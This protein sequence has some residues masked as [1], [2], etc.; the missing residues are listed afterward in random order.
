MMCIFYCSSGKA[1]SKMGANGTSEITAACNK[2]CACSTFI[3]Q[4]VCGSNNVAYF[5]PCHAGCMVKLTEKV[6][7]NTIVSRFTNIS[8]CVPQ[9]ILVCSLTYPHVLLTYPHVFPNI[10]SCVPYHILMCSLTYPN[11][12]PNI[13]SCVP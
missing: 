10:S 12:F 5:D 7:R 1:V 2:P 4:P 6:S 9:Y 13:S 3:S 8:S 11:V